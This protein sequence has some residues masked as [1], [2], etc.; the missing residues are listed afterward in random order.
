M[1]SENLKN[2]SKLHNKYKKIFKEIFSNLNFIWGSFDNIFDQELI[3]N[4]KDIFKNLM[5][6]NTGIIKKLNTTHV[7]TT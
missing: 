7:K 3:L 1:K 6:L 5:I 4:T 2:I